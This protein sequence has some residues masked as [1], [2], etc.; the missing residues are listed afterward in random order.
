MFSISMVL[1]NGN[2]DDSPELSPYYVKQG[3]D[4]YVKITP[5]VDGLVVHLQ[6]CQVLSQDGVK[7]HDLITKG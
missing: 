6:Q 1:L 7:S 3:S 2:R 5:D 4:I